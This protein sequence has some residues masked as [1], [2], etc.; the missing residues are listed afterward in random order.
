MSLKFI[1][2]FMIVFL[3]NLN[4]L[5]EIVEDL[6]YFK[7]FKKFLENLILKLG[8]ILKMKQNLIDAEFDFL[9][10]TALHYFKKLTFFKTNDSLVKC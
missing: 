1:Q 4:I 6:I 5:L 3:S 9:I 2:F 7:S 8:F 10:T